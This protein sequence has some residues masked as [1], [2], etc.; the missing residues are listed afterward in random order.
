MN[1]VL[2]DYQNI[3]SG[4]KSILDEEDLIRFRH[5][6]KKTGRIATRAWLDE[7]V[8]LR[9]QKLEPRDPWTNFCVESGKEK[10]KK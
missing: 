6:A 7:Q 1:T 2:S 5:R 3:I 8:I 10:K 4:L 9:E